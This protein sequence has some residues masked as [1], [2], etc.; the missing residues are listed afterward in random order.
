MGYEIAW[1]PC[2][3]IKRF[4]GEVSSS[5]LMN[6]SST[7]QGDARFDDLQYVIFDFQDCISHSVTN[8]ALQDIAAIDEFASESQ[9]SLRNTPVK[10]AIVVNNPKINDLA[11]QY[12]NYRP[13]H[14][15]FALFSNSLD[16]RDWLTSS[17]GS[18]EL[19]SQ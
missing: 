4:Y 9:A 17:E 12:A 14:R 19:A 2:G 10:V 7:V 5:D 16:A 13:S 6:A 15:S 18:L 8:A 11:K 1:E 3:V